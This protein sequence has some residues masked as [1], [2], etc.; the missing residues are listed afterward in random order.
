MAVILL[1]PT[2]TNQ[3]MYDDYR[4]IGE[5]KQVPVIPT[6]DET[7]IGW[8][9]DKTLKLLRYDNVHFTRFGNVRFAALCIEEISRYIL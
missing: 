3:T 5:N 9:R 7:L 4:K 2:R 6:D 8:E 1:C